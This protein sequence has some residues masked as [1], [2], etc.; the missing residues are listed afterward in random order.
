MSVSPEMIRLVYDLWEACV[1]GHEY[2]MESDLPSSLDKLPRSEWG[3][4]IRT[5][6]NMNRLGHL[7]AMGS[8]PPEFLTSLAGKEIIDTVVKLKPLLD[9]ERTRRSD[10]AYLEFVDQLLAACRERYPDYEPKYQP[11]RRAAGLPIG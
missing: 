3:D 8:L 9:D 1:P 2:V 5:L 4:V 11:R 10:P 6:R 7:M